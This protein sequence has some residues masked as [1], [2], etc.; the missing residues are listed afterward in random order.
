MTG[1]WLQIDGRPYDV[2]VLSIKESAS[3]LYSDKTGR[4]MSVGARMTL[5]PLGTFIGHTIKVKRKGNNVAEYDR[6]YNYIIKPRFNGIRVKAVHDQTTIDYDAY[7]SSAEREIQRI[8]DVGKVVYWKE[9][10]INIVPM[11]AQILPI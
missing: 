11:E 3:I 8:D 2:S 7:I 1:D 5:D 4:T 6:L 9:M 10:D